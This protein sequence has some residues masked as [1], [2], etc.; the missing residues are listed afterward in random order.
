MSQWPPAAYR[1]FDTTDYHTGGE[2]FRIVAE[3]PAQ[4]LAPGLTVAQRRVVAI[5][6]EQVQWARS[7]LCSEPRGHADMYGGFVVPPDDDGAHL[8]VLFWH[9]DGF[10]TACGHGTIALA[11]WAVESG[12]LPAP[13][14]GATDVVVDVPSGRVTATVVMRAGQI[15]SVRFTNVA[16]YVHAT[17]VPVPTTR[18]DV[19]VDIAFGGAMYAVLPAAAVG[20]RV[21]PGDYPALI[22]IGRQIRDHLNATDAAEHPTDPRLSGVYGTILTEQISPVQTRPDGSW[23][24]HQRNVTVFADG[25]VDRSPC[26]SGTSARVAQLSALGELELGDE[27]VHESIIGSVFRARIVEHLRAHGRPAVIPQVSGTAY[28]MGQSRFHVDP[29]DGLVPGFTLR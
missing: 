28:L 7:L 23:L 16:S 2:P 5:G 15:E 25:E 29:R 6:S 11:A 8:G 26:G 12:R 21:A 9:K 1:A 27:L 10:S 22:D 13:L 24:L 17:G 20:L 19:V 3:P 14:D 4:L 18:G